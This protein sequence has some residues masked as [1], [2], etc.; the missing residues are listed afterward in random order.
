MLARPAT[1]KRLDDTFSGRLE[2][3]DDESCSNGVD[4]HDRP[5]RYVV[6]QDNGSHG[7]RKSNLNIIVRARRPSTFLLDARLA[8]HRYVPVVLRVL[9]A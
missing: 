5:F 6:T 7:A 9:H 4:I 1:K 8:E 2:L 3:I